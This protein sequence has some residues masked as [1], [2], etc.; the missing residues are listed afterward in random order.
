[1]D[2]RKFLAAA[3]TTLAL[4][5]APAHGAFINGGISFSDGFGSTG[6][7]TSIVSEL[8]FIDVTN[9]V[10]AFN[11]SGDFGAA[12]VSP[13]DYARDFNVGAVNQLIFEYQGFTFIVAEFLNITRTPL[14]CDTIEPDQCFDTLTFNGRGVVS[15]PGFDDTGFLLAWTAQ[16]TCTQAQ[17]TDPICGSNVNASWS[18]S[19]SATGRAGFLVPEPQTAALLG[20]GLVALALIRRRRT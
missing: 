7:T 2:F 15:G 4:A 19:I 6:T 13:G 8:V 17:G 1:M 16:G 3:A 12:C 11:C 10:Q 20:L 9:P 18:A 5:S 14:V